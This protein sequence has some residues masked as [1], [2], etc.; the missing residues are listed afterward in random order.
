MGLSY[1]EIHQLRNIDTAQLEPH[2]GL[3]FIVGANGSGK[4]S[5]LEAIYLLGRGRSFRSAQVRRML[6]HGAAALT[7]F[8]RIETAGRA[9]HSLGIE[10]GAQGFRARADGRPLLRASGLAELLPLLFISPDGDRLVRGSPRQRRRFIDW[11]LFHVEPGYLAVWQRYNRALAQ[12]NAALRRCGPQWGSLAAWDTALIEAA[13]A[14]DGA[15]RGFLDQFCPLF[16]HYA[17][18]LLGDSDLDCHYQP[19]W[20]GEGDY[21]TALREGWERDRS[22]G[23]TQ[24]GPHRA[25]LVLQTQGRSAA[26]VLSGGQQKLAACAL[27]LAHAAV[28]NQHGPRPCVLLVD[29]L[30]AELDTQHRQ[31]LLKLLEQVGGQAFVTSTDIAL[32]DAKPG[33][34]FHVEQGRVS[35]R[36]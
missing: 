29:D 9:G 33:A 10:I 16:R 4:T 32:L 26:E 18:A 8:G 14:V 31:R 20:S 17:Q 5:L 36:G 3:N 30:A 1:L 22:S 6:H 23:L 15:R 24:R 28:L 27:I 19:G 35:K 12:R 7:V 13:L 21:A 2:P 25:D 34:V 11:G